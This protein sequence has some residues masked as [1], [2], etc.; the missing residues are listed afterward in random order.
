MTSEEKD[1]RMQDPMLH[2][3]DIMK[4]FDRRKPYLL[5]LQDPADPMN[6][7]GK[8]AYGIKHVQD[9]FRKFSQQL[10]D[11]MKEW[12][13][14]KSNRNPYGLLG[15]FLEA[16]YTALDY[17]RCKMRGWVVKR[18][19]SLTPILQESFPPEQYRLRSR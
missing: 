4:T 19:P 12:D 15:N 2:G 13:E 1:I 17:Q 16:S 18:D 10:K 7:L 8:R 11:Q 5:C 14:D 6:D 3:I 9:M